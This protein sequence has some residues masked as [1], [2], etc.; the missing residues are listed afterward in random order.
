MAS[1]P[2]EPRKEKRRRLTRQVVLEG[3]SHRED[4]E[5]PGYPGYYVTIRP[6]RDLEVMELVSEMGK[7]GGGLD[8]L[9]ALAESPEGEAQLVEALKTDSNI[10]QLMRK[11]C[12]LGIVTDTEEE[13]LGPVLDEMI[14]FGSIIIG[15]KI[16]ALS[17]ITDEGIDDFFDLG[18]GKPSSSSTSED[19]KSE[20]GEIQKT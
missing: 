2:K 19:G 13:D 12:E 6:L 14:G 4:V 18:M 16:F 5:L 15:M 7:A 17:H 11:V 8:E 3:I 20:E 9:R 1:K 10:M